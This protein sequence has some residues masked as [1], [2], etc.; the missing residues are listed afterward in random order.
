[1]ELN[2][3]KNEEMKNELGQLGGE[4]SLALGKV[5]GN[6]HELKMGG[7]RRRRGGSAAKSVGGKKSKRRSGKSR[8]SRKS[9]RSRK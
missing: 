4:N 7:R 2:D 8:K 5:G 1:M 3:G 6:A 9:R